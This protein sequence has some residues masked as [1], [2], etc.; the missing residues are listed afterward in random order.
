MT[1]CAQEQVVSFIFWITLL[2]SINLSNNILFDVKAQVPKQ[3]KPLDIQ[4]SLK[5]QSAD[6]IQEVCNNLAHTSAT[7][8]L[9][10]ILICAMIEWTK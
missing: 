8:A 3:Y 9:R 5:T 4:L 6:N 7:I 10:I 1:S 2:T